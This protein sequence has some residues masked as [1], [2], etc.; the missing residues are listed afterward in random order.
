M[1]NGGAQGR[2][3]VFDARQKLSAKAPV[4]ARDKIIINKKSGKGDARNKIVSKQ[5]QKGT[6]DARSLIQRHKKK[7]QGQRKGPAFTAV[8][9]PF[10]MMILSAFFLL[11]RT[12]LMMH[13]LI[14]LPY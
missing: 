3:P 7:A 8:S 12:S 6:F 9:L 5:V 13:C 2:G 4:D 11:P 1:K 10:F 14:Y